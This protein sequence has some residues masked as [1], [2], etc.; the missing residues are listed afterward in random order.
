MSCFRYVNSFED[1][2]RRDTQI[3]TEVEQFFAKYQWTV[4]YKVNTLKEELPANL[5]HQA[6]EFPTKIYWA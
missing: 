5:L 4:S 6:G 2:P 1:Y 3:S